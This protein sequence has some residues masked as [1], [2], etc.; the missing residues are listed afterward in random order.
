[1][2]HVVVVYHSGWGHTKAQAEA[3]LRGVQQVGNVT[4]Q[5]VSVDDFQTYEQDFER[6]DAIVFGCPTYM[7][8]TSAAFKTFMDATSKIWHNQK[9]ANKIAAGFTNSGS[10]NGDKLM[11]LTQLFTFAMQ[12][13]MVW[14]G[15]GLMPGNNSSHGSVDDLNRLGSFMGA[16]AQSNIDQS[17]DQAPPEADLKTAEHLGTRVAKATLNWKKI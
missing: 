7:G 10:Q 5:L 4:G 12:H 8:S 1:M 9:W 3:V 13:S 17:A 15:L 6:A 2:S 16:I 14:I 11:T